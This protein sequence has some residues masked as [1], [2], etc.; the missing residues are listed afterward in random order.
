MIQQQ[1][2]IA[3]IASGMKPEAMIIALSPSRIGEDSPCRAG[4]NGKLRW[5]VP[6]SINDTVVLEESDIQRSQN[7][8]LV[9]RP[10]TGGDAWERNPTCPYLLMIIFS[11]YGFSAAIH[12]MASMLSLTMPDNCGTPGQQ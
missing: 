9:D 10:M 7:H 2:S 5:Q 1:E 6:V 11:G 12:S 4:E 8:P 3:I